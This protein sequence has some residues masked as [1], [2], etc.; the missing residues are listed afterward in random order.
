IG[1][2]VLENGTNTL[3]VAMNTS[4]QPFTN[5]TLIPSLAAGTFHNTTDTPDGIELEGA[6]SG[7][8]LSEPLNAG[9]VSVLTNSTVTWHEPAGTNMTVMYGSN[10]TGSL[11]A[12]SFGASFD[13]EIVADTMRNRA[14][15][16][17]S[18]GDSNT[19][20]G[21]QNVEDQDGDGDVDASD[22]T[23]EAGC[24]AQRQYGI[25]VYTIAY[26][27]DADFEELNLTAQCGGGKMYRSNITDLKRIFYQVSRAII[28]AT[29]QAQ[30]IEVTEGSVNQTLYPDSYLRMN[31]SS[32]SRL[33]FGK[34]RITQNSGR[35]GGNV[36]SPKYGRFMIP[37]Q[38]EILNARLL[39]YSS[40]YWTDRV[41]VENQSGLHE[42]VFRLWQYGEEYRDLGDPYQVHIPPSILQT[43]RINN[44]SINT[45]LNR[46]DP[47]GGSPDARVIYQL[48]VSG[49]VGYGDVF[50]KSDGGTTNV[51]R[52]YGNFT[53][54]VGLENDTWDPRQDA[55]DNATERLL[56]K[57]DVDDD[58]TVD[59]QLD[60]DNLDID[61][62]SLS[63][64]KWLWGPARVTLEVWEDE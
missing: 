8:W 50:N 9:Q 7:V 55:L 64:L 28:E 39:S 10:A 40:N 62:N 14:M 2:S 4:H 48:Q 11:N 25:S 59:F 20:T 33:E 16:V 57:L 34:F 29:F 54:E 32:P 37:N 46:T 56:N 3:A 18:D 21:M 61:E 30:R 35:F 31:Y 49:L 17:L 60:A 27:N 24:R 53:L 5:T 1:D 63:G 41:T 15:V 44:V 58:G 22:H 26:G 12:S 38:T 19:E 36:S 13:L 45:A 51:S 47:V 6:E 52:D 43:G 42:Y 23:I